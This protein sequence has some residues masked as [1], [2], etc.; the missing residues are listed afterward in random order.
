MPENPDSWSISGTWSISGSGIG[1]MAS[2]LLGDNEPTQP[3]PVGQ[4]EDDE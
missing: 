1:H 2:V 4:A 3:K